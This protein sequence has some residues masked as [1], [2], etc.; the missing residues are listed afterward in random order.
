MVLHRLLSP[1]PHNAL[2]NPLVRAVASSSSLRVVLHIPPRG[3]FVDSGSVV[4][5]RQ[6]SGLFFEIS[7]DIPSL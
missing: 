3:G 6:V 1:F 5:V 7:L 2:L 4:D